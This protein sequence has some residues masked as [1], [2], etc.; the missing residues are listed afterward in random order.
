MVIDYLK[1]LPIL[2]QLEHRLDE[3]LSIEPI[4]PDRAD[5]EELIQLLSCEFFPQ[6]LGSFININRIG[7]V[8]LQ[9]RPFFHTVKDV[10]GADVK[11][12]S[13]SRPSSDGY[14]P[15][16]YPIDSEDFILLVFAAIDIG[17]SRGMDDGI[18]LGIPGEVHSRF[19]VCDIEISATN[20]DCLVI[21][22]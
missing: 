14:I 22:R 3:V 9:I 7:F 10:I 5:D 13:I 15:G 19:K 17:E 2:S 4:E 16:S 6:Q 11:E 1:L 21:V 12:P 20:R 18:R 8:K